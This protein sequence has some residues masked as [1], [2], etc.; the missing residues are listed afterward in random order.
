MSFWFIG[1][2]ECDDPRFHQAGAGACGL[3]FMAGSQCMRG[4]YKRDLPAE[5]FVPD[6]WVR[7]WP[8]G[9]RAAGRLV[10]VGLW[11]RADGGYYYKWI[12]PQNTPDA[13]RATREMERKKKDRARTAARRASFTVIPGAS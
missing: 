7:R 5:W 13:L 1:D 10:Q 3:Y 12:R 8:N 11:E 2:E 6:H 4:V 9:A